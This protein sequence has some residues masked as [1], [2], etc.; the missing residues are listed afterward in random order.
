MQDFFKQQAEWL[1]A[2]QGSQEKL[3]KQYAEQGSEWM[4]SVLGQKK[5]E[6]DF[7][8]GWFKSQ[9]DLVDQFMEFSKRLQEMI[10][11]SF[12]DKLPPDVLKLMNTSFFEEFYKGLIH[13]FF[14]LFRVT[15]VTVADF[16]GKPTKNIIE[17]LLAVAIVIAATI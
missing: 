7:F 17:L 16:H 2:W 10:S 5:P 14:R 13:D 6:P 15:G 9:G 8:E 11:R 3:A 12:G 4:E 1:N